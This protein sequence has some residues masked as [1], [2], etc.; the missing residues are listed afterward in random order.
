LPALPAENLVKIGRVL[1]IGDLEVIP[2]AVSMR[3]VRLVNSIDPLEEREVETS[4][5]VLKLKFHNA[6]AKKILVPLAPAFIRDSNAVFDRSFIEGGN[7]QR[8]AIFPLAVDSE[9]SIA[10][11][12]FP[13][14][15]P[16]EDAETIVASAPVMGELPFEMTWRLRLR[17][18]A[19]RTDVVGVKF[20]KSE[21][22]VLS[23]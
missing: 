4:S 21:V 2:L 13:T 1:R 10:E 8:I 7:G 19:Y 11:Q 3:S 9:W 18:A 22:E 16:G 5:L 15:K 6:S 12:E 23:Q 17:I 20:K 14:V